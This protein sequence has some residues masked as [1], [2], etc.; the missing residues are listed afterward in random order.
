M[1][2]EELMAYRVWLLYAE[3]VVSGRPRAGHA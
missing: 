1:I 2:C 3:W